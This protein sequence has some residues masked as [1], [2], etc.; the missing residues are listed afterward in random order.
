MDFETRRIPM[1]LKLNFLGRLQLSLGTE[2]IYL[3]TGFTDELISETHDFLHFSGRQEHSKDINFF[4]KYEGQYKYIP[5]RSKWFN[6]P[7]IALKI[8]IVDESYFPFRISLKLSCK[9]PSGAEHLLSSSSKADYAGVFLLDYK[10]QK[11]NFYLNFGKVYA[12]KIESMKSINV[13]DFLYGYIVA[14]YNITERLRTLIQLSAM[15]SPYRKNKLSGFRGTPIEILFGAGYK[16]REYL[17]IDLG[18]SQDLSLAAPEFG[19]SLGINL[20]F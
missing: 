3:T 2:Y 4:L 15:Q 13:D 18:F 19:L 5:E 10:I 9:K 12:G 17:I 20:Y 16:L 6:D 8:N 14:E 11:F 7:I 1:E